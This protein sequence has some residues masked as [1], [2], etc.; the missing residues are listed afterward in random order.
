MT[1]DSWLRG[2]ALPRVWPSQ[3]VRERLCWSLPTN[4]RQGASLL[5]T[6]AT[7]VALVGRVRLPEAQLELGATVVITGSLRKHVLGVEY[8]DGVRDV[9]QRDKASLLPPLE[10]QLGDQTLVPLILDPI[11]RIEVAIQSMW[12]RGRRW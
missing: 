9:L 6:A 7:G 11:V 3:A 4:G 1:N 8:V 10:A 5:I 12:R 2:W